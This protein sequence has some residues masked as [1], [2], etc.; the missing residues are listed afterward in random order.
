M[1]NVSGRGIESYGSI[2]YSSIQ[3]NQ[4]I[5]SGTMSHAGTVNTSSTGNTVTLTGGTSFNSVWA[6]SYI[7]INGALYT[8]AT[9]T[10]PSTM[11]LTTNPGNQSGAAYLYAATT[12]GIDTGPASYLRIKGNFVYKSGGCGIM[13]DGALNYVVEGNVVGDSGQQKNFTSVLGSYA[14]IVLQ[15]DNGGASPSSYNTIKNNVIFDDQAPQT[16]QWG[17]KEGW[18]GTNTALYYQ[19]NLIAFNQVTGSG[20]QGDISQATA[21]GTVTDNV[22]CNIDAAAYNTDRNCLAVN[23]YLG[24]NLGLLVGP[25]AD[26]TSASNNSLQALFGNLPIAKIKVG[27]GSNGGN[28]N[29]ITFTYN[30]AIPL[31]MFDI[32]GPYIGNVPLKINA[33]AIALPGGADSTVVCWKVAAGGMRMIGYATVAEITVGTCH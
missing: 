18:T 9:V 11:T 14:G 12:C 31:A 3:D 7:Q 23:S 8:I 4:I 21:A 20:V 1:F 15:Y 30:D 22:F 17:I 19:R 10:P 28:D 32:S 26:S 2:Q 29:G 5:N 27:T 33:S 13:L 24:S 6:G 25:N 16:Q